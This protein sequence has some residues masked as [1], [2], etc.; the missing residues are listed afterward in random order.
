M[1]HFDAGT[2]LMVGSTGVVARWCGGYR[3]VWPVDAVTSY[4]GPLEG[5]TEMS[6]NG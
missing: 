6:L 5:A 4:G 1:V 2:P 3:D